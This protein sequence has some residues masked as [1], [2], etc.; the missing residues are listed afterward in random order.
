MTN[1]T[2]KHIWSGG[3]VMSIAIV[4]FLAAFVVLVNNPGAAMAHE[5][6]DHAAACEA[7]TDAERAR[8]DAVAMASWARRRAARPRTRSQEAQPQVGG[9]PT[10][11]SSRARSFVDQ[12]RDTPRL[13]HVLVVEDEDGLNP[14]YSL[15]GNDGPAAT[16]HGQCR[17]SSTWA[18][19]SPG[20]C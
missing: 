11:T 15:G 7:L 3:V 20:D 10:P 18:T 9:A 13:R 16:R 6:A 8:H 19:S 5:D 12:G 1:K 4:G 14:N 17:R 2:R